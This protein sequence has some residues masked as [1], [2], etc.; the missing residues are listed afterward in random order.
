[1]VRC[2]YSCDTLK[3][4]ESEATTYV[5]VVSVAKLLAPLTVV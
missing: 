1:V 4:P 5:E 2:S 3:N